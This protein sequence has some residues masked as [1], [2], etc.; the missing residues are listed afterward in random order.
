MEM[1]PPEL[2]A[3]VDHMV[4]RAKRR[5]CTCPSPIVWDREEMA[6]HLDNL[7]PDNLANVRDTLANHPRIVIFL[8]HEIGC[9]IVR[10]EWAPY[11]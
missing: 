1:I 8:D 5:G 2:Q 11:N 9:H 7:A 6:Q 4:D 10:T 3:T